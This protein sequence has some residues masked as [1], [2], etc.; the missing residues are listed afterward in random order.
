MIRYIIKRYSFI[1]VVF[2]NATVI[3]LGEIEN[4]NLKSYDISYKVNF[5]APLL[6][7]QKIIPLMK[8]KNNGIIVFVSSSGAAPYMGA[9]EIYKTAQVE[10]ANTLYAEIEKTNI[11]VYTIGPGLV[12]TETAANAIEIISKKLGMSTDE[13]YQM[14]ESRILRKEEAGL[15]FALSVLKS[16][17]YSGQEIGST[18][19]L[20]DFGINKTDN[21]NKDLDSKTIEIIIK[22]IQA[23]N[24]QYNGWKNLNI[25]ERQWVLRDFKK[26]V[27]ISSDECNENLIHLLNTVKSSNII[28]LDYLSLFKKLKHYFQVQYKLLQGWEKNPEKLKN[29]SDYLLDLINNIE[30]IIKI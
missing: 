1:D 26:N 21:E 16:K 19:V 20:N 27:G 3:F 15:G 7:T 23:F 8:N 22:V 13:F 17:E 4:V 2:N 30:I 28:Q 14:N 9:Y 18:L 5:I 10:L 6:I 24:E 29:H 25:F 11:S 12:K